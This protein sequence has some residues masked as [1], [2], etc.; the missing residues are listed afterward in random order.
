MTN[1]NRRHTPGKL[2]SGKFED[3]RPQYLNYLTEL[4]QMG[5]EF[6][7]FL[8]YFS[9]FTGDL[10]IL[11]MLTLYE[12]FKEVEEISGHIADVG[13]FRGASSFW[14]AKLTKIYSPNS[15]TQVHGFDWFNGNQPDKWEKNIVIGGGKESF[16]RVNKLN[17]L[18]RLDQILKIHK[19]DLVTQL[20]EFF[21]DYPHLKFKLIFMDAGMYKVVQAALPYFWDRL[22]VGGL[23]IFDQYNFEVAPG[24]TK[25]VDEFFS[26]SDVTIK[27]F[28]NS[29]MPTAYVK[30]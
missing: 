3:R 28:K 29:W 6:E 19:L 16:N 25:A 8:H 30:K 14:F 7:D 13:M 21:S 4:K 11:R 2:E 24:E 12:A 1:F 26:G 15:L 18:Q 27:T 17:E 9:C 10:T 23:M 22:S 20:D 5:Y